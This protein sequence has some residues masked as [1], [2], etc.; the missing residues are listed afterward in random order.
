MHQVQL[1]LGGGRYL[2]LSSVILF[3]ASVYSYLIYKHYLNASE[4][5]S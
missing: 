3:S 4:K 2:L 5:M 1:C